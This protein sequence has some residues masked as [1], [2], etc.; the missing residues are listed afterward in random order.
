MDTTSASLLAPGIGAASVALSGSDHPWWIAIVI[1]A[2]TCMPQIRATALTI[3]DITWKWKH[4]PC[5]WHLQHVPVIFEG[6]D[7]ATEPDLPGGLCKRI[8]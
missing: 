7:R 8:G 6:D 2:L 1:V 5:S 4:S 3:S